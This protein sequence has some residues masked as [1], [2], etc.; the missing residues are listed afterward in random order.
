MA[1]QELV[2]TSRVLAQQGGLSSGSVFQ[3]R[4]DKAVLESLKRIATTT[5]GA[6]VINHLLETAELVSIAQGNGSDLGIT[7]GNKTQSGKIYIDIDINM[8]IDPYFFDVSDER[9]KVDLTRVLSHE[10]G[11]AYI[12]TIF[13][14][15]GFGPRRHLAIPIENA[16]ST[17]L[18][19]NAS[20]RHPNMGH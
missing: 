5:E 10:L 19:T 11:H 6:K 15:H 1:R 14:H 8:Q 3:I 20:V 16:I 4:N 18:D 13:G 9:F 2:K 7:V 17:Q 12:Y